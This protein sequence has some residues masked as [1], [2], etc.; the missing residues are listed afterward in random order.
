M[1]RVF[2]LLGVIGVLV[3]GSTAVRAA[4][5][6][7]EP[8]QPTAY[9]WS[10]FYLGAIGSYGFG[11]DDWSLDGQFDLDG[12]AFGGGVIGYNQQWDSFVLGGELS[13]QFGHMQESGWPDF[14]YETLVDVKARAG[15]AM[16]RA[17]F[18]VAGG[19]SF[20]RFDEEGDDF[21]LHGYNV[22]GGIDFALTEN[23]VLGAEYTFRGLNGDSA[24]GQDVDGKVSTVSAKLTYKF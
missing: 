15:F 5:L 3:M 23:V 11:E 8:A 21:D 14:T 24:S 12:A 6:T 16:D 20:A 17:L 18:Y 9:D 4:D 7:A 1:Q 10:G 2:R 13:A 22:G 19:Y